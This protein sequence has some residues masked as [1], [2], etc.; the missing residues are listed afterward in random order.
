MNKDGTGESPNLRRSA[1][2]PYGDDEID[3]L[4]LRQTLV[5]GRRL[6]FKSMAIAVSLTVVITLLMPNIY[7]AEVKM[8]PAATEDSK[9]GLSSMMG[10]LGGLASLAGVSAGGAG[11]VDENL[12]VLQSKEF[13]WKF[14]QESQM[15]PLLF[16]PGMVRK[17]LEMV[18]LGEPPGQ[19]DVY[20]LLIEDKVLEVTND[21]KTGIVTVAMQWKDPELAA[22]WGNAIVARLNQ[23]LAQQ[24][25]ARSETNL[26]YLNEQ[27]GKVQVEEMRKTLFDLIASEQKN[28]MLANTQKDFAFKVIDPAITPDK[29]AKPKRLLIVLL[30]LALSFFLSS[31]YVLVKEGGQS[32]SS[33]KDRAG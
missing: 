9:K 23:Y 31:V 12:A 10:G 24:A 7:R 28:A 25:I 21:D 20:R 19:W 17:T 33:N 32:G 4:A 6:I 30:A 8:V 11:S 27:L 22:V 26:Q 5:K 3:L 1:P 2:S 14:V 13:L 29:K 15:M 18:G 16:E